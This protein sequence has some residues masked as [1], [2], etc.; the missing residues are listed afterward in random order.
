MVEKLE[1]L[2]IKISY[3]ENTIETLNNNLLLQ[4]QDI[5]ELKNQLKALTNLLQKIKQGQVDNIKLASEEILA[6]HY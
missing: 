2:E 3:Q 4:Q 6:P 5:L 1:K